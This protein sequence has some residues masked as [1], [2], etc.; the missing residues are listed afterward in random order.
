MRQCVFCVVFFVRFFFINSVR[1]SANSEVPYPWHT[2]VDTQRKN[3]V[4]CRNRSHVESRIQTFH[5]F[6]SVALVNNGRSGVIS[7]SAAS[8]SNNILCFHFFQQGSVATESEL[9]LVEFG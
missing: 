8:I 3:T 9:C 2:A 6:I 4:S 1:H 5:I 7:V